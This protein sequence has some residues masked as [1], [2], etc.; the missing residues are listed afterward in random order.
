MNIQVGLQQGGLLFSRRQAQQVCSTHA[1]VRWPQPQQ[2]V[3][4]RCRD[5]LV[6]AGRTGDRRQTPAQRRG[7]GQPQRPQKPAPEQNLEDEEEDDM[8]GESVPERSEY[9][10]YRDPDYKPHRFIGNIQIAQIPG[11]GRGLVATQETDMG[12]LLVT[13]T[14]LARLPGA[15]QKLPPEPEELHMSWL[16]DGVTAAQRRVLDVLY[17]GTEASMARDA[18][19]ATLDPKFWSSRGKNDPQAPQVSSGRLL[20]IIQSCSCSDSQQDGAAMAVRHQKPIGFIGLWAEHSLINHSCAPNTSAI[21]VEDRMLIHS[22]QP[23]EAGEEL[24]RNYSGPAATM[25]APQRRAALKEMGMDFHCNCPRCTLEDQVGEDVQE[26][27][28]AAYLWYSEEALPRFNA[29]NESEDLSVLKGLLEEAETLV[30]EL[31]ATVDAQPE[32]SELE[33]TMLRA[34]AYDTYD[35]VVVCSE[36]IFQERCSAEPLLQCLELLMLIAPGGE[37]HAAVS[38]KYHDLLTNRHQMMEAMIKQGTISRTE[39]NKEMWVRL[40]E[41]EK[42]SQEYFIQAWVSRYGYLRN[43]TFLALREG[44]EMYTEGMEQMSLMA[45]A[46]QTEKSTDYVINGVTVSVVDKAD[47]S[48]GGQA[49]EEEVSSSSSNGVRFSLIQQESA[50]TE[51]E[52][53]SQEAGEQGLG[54]AQEFTHEGLEEGQQGV[55]VQVESPQQ[56]VDETAGAEAVPVKAP[57]QLRVKRKQR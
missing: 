52:L 6:A 46:G 49:G 38:L 2:V 51:T 10:V 53:V 39:E 19:L 22:A 25:P 24:T 20:S 29:A 31:E 11:R 42:M 32:L 17:D 36:L 4:H 8:Q 34:S 47:L 48:T 56:G 14:A 9:Q 43:S 23:V 18:S 37:A 57:R 12:E 3:Q 5:V 55:Q 1:T 45:A 27:L 26:I 30:V 41:E 50:E 35:M 16:E 21:V 33:R 13:S 54:D 7:F 40:T 28:Q 44:F 15:W